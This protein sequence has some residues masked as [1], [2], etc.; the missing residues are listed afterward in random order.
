MPLQLGVAQSERDNLMQGRSV[1]CVSAAAHGSSERPFLM[2]RLDDIAVMGL[3]RMTPGERGRAALSLF[4]SA[5]VLAEAGVR[6]LHPELNDLQAKEIVLRRI[7]SA[8]D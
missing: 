6:T 1:D 7:R 3:R 2:E 8:R 5:I 4:D